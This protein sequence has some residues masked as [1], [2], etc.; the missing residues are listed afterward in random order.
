MQGTR[1]AALF[2]KK[3]S[4]WLGLIH[5]VT[6]H[7]SRTGGSGETWARRPQLRGAPTRW[8]ARHLSRGQAAPAMPS[9]HPPTPTTCALWA[10]T[11]F[12]SES[13]R[14]FWTG[15]LHWRV[16]VLFRRDAK[17]HCSVSDPSLHAGE[18]QPAPHA[19]TVGK[20]AACVPF[21]VVK[22]LLM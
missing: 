7:S 15:K 9:F 20:A 18:A 1:R 14:F 8:A 16:L 21:R 10:A 5:S 2:G 22:T 11:N 13:Y 19:N 6:R 4:Y 17:S 12:F 3:W